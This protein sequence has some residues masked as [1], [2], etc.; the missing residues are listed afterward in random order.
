M[1]TIYNPLV[2]GFD[3]DPSVVEVDGVYYLVTSTFEYVPGI[4][5]YRS[6]DFE[7]WHH[8]GNV[9]VTTEQLGVADVVTMLGVWAPTIRHRDGV[10]HVI[11]TIAGSPKQCVVYR[12]SEAAGPWDDGTTIVG[13]D[14]IDPD[15]A[16]DEQGNAYVTYSGL[17]LSG[18]ELGRHKG[19]QQVRV[20]L[21]TGTALE[22]PRSLWSG[23]GLQFPE[24]PHVFQRGDHW[25]LMIAEGGTERGHG[26]SIARGPSIEGPFEGAPSN[27]VLSARSTTRPIQNTGHAD[28]VR[29][30]DG[31]DALV[32]LGMR[33]LGMTR[34]FSPLG[35]ETFATRVHWVDGWPQPEPVALNPRPGVL[36]ETFDFG[37]TDGQG[38]ED[39]SNQNGGNQNGAGLADHGWLTPRNEPTTVARVAGG[40]LVVTATGDDLSD[41]RPAFVGRRQRHLVSTTTVTVDAA[42][43]CGGLALRYDENLYLALQ[44]RGRTVTAVAALPSLRQTWS[45]ELPEG[46]ITLTLETELPPVGFSP[47]AA[48][49]DRIRLV[50]AAGGHRVQLAEVDGRFWTAESAGGSFTGRVIGV[51]AGEG[52]VTF[53]SITYRGQEPSLAPGG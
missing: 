8:I 40:R 14:G 48:G 29:L 52:V 46:E 26:V 35:R 9:G 4:P 2:P 1:T 47:E 30:P 22:A 39:G 37:V 21:A 12:A 3:P 18:E 51:Y 10:F 36:T 38:T 45:T 15:L 53:G 7:T 27:P 34:Q 49:A 42:D 24:A 44:A 41:P 20:D 23:T 6:E 31:D 50:A 5:V 16:W 17:V 28:L 25:Y 19:I 32:L 33:P 11:V 43:G 13:V